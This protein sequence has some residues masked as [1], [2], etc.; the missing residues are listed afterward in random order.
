[1]HGYC[2]KCVNMHSFWRI[3][4]EDFWGKICKIGCFL[5]FANV[6]IHWCGCFNIEQKCSHVYTWGE[7]RE[8]R[9]RNG[10]LIK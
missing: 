9:E 6:Y 7:E 10:K 2:S 1:M 8:K 3:D 5:Y 4:V